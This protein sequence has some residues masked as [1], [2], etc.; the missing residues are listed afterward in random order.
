VVRIL[1][2]I[3]KEDVMPISL[4]GLGIDE[5]AEA[6]GREIDVQVG[7]AKWLNHVAAFGY[8][9]NAVWLVNGKYVSVWPFEYF[10]W[11]MAAD[12]CLAL[13]DYFN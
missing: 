10:H 5:A 12:Y 6:L 2:H 4:G 13:P 9:H 7:Y 1:I 11:L 8:N 3:P